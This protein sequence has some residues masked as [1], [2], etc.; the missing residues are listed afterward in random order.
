[1]F[2]ALDCDMWLIDDYPIRYYTLCDISILAP[3][4]MMVMSS[5][6]VSTMSSGFVLAN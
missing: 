3:I 5:D 4:F 2:L 1:M 6:F